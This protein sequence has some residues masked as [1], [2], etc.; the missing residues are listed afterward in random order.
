MSNQMDH[1]ELEA[2]QQPL[3]APRSPPSHSRTAWSAE[4][5]SGSPSTVFSVTSVSGITTIML[6]VSVF[7]SQYL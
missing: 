6:H 7:T 1:D 5:F 3:P 4:P 2:G